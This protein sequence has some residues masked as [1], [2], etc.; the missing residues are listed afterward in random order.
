[1]IVRKELN[2]ELLLIPQT[3]HSRMVGQFAAHW[4]NERFARPEPFDS[5]ARAATFHDF[6]WLRY[7]TAPV[8]DP[9]THE[10]PNF[11]G[12]PSTTARLEEYQWCADWFMANDP[13][14]SLIVNMHRTGLWR[15]RYGSVLHPKPI[16]RSQ[17]RDV[18][19]YIE[20]NE[21]RQQRE[22]ATFDEDQ[23][24]TNYRLLQVWDLLGLYFGC[25][26]PSEDYIEPVPTSYGNGK[27]AEGVRLS[28][29]PQGPHR[30]AVDPFPFDMRPC[31]VQL[32][33]RRLPQ[34]TYED[35][36]AF[37]AAYFRAPVELME[38]ELV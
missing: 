26:E 15:E 19:E 1:M 12:M 32:V 36:D 8:V 2:G 9:E 17:T 28:L 22:R 38:F 6:G 25:Q 24:W 35:Q 14:S 4:G 37:R 31:R 16:L 7:E 33:S 34:V 13:Y 27:A 20:R 18:D 21:A 3:E 10:T 30:V 29:T 23:V 11:R 5:V